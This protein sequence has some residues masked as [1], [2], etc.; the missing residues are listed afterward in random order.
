MWARWCELAVD[1]AAETAPVYRV[2]PAFQK[3]PVAG[4]DPH[5]LPTPEEGRP[6]HGPYRRVHPR[7]V[8]PTCQDPYSHAQLLSRYPERSI[9]IRGASWDLTGESLEPG[10]C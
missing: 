8:A 7:R 1:D 3:P 9:R 2:D 10:A 4:P 5:D 6:R